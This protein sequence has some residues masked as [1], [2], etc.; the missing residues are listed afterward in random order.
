MK[1]K[2][3]KK[4]NKG[5][6]KKQSGQ[7]QQGAKQMRKKWSREVDYLS[8][9]PTSAGLHCFFFVSPLSMS[10]YVVGAG[11]GGSLLSFCHTSRLRMRALLGRAPPQR[12]LPHSASRPKVGEKWETAPEQLHLPSLCSFPSDVLSLVNPEEQRRACAK[13][14]VK[15]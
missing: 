8:L 3:C 9:P 11:L 2:K 1:K 5:A 7:G 6:E 13:Q 15:R 4:K 10:L 12:L 14:A